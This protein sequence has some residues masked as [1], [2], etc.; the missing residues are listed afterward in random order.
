MQVCWTE[1]SPF[2]KE[3]Q[4]GGIYASVDGHAALKT[5][6]PMQNHQEAIF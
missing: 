5:Q 3:E 2:T 4:N 1:F 6:D